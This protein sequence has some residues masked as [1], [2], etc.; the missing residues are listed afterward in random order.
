M[1]IGR[2]Y[3]LDKVNFCK[4]YFLIDGC[5]IVFLFCLNKFKVFEILKDF[6]DV[7]WLNIFEFEDGL[8]LNIFDCMKDDD[9]VGLFIEDR[10]FIVLMEKELYID[11]DGYWCLL[12][13]FCFLWKFLLNNRSMVV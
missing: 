3:F 9:I 13:L 8:V 11:E 5:V 1:C 2:N 6:D 4:I 7:K 12:L 10:V